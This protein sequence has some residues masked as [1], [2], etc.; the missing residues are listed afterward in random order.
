MSFVIV[1]EKEFIA[2]LTNRLEKEPIKHAKIAVQLA[3]D[4][5]RNEA[6]NSIARG[7]KSGA[8]VQKYNPKR[9]H[10]QSASGEAPATDTGFLISQISASSKVEGTTAIGEVKSSAPYSKH[11]EYGT[12]NMSKRPFMQPALDRSAKKIKKIF[13]REGLLGRKGSKK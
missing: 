10:Q 5:V 6:I 7:S 9:T 11:L 8:T 3:A 13:I 1:N 2:K 4:A 12:V